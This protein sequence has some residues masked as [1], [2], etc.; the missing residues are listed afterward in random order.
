VSATNS[1]R[2][3]AAA[4]LVILP[5]CAELPFLQP[6]TGLEFQ[7]SGR[8]AVRYDG[9]G[10]SGNIAWR[11]RAAGDEMLI[12]TPLGQ[13]VARIERERDMVTVTASDRRVYRAHDAESLTEQV[14]GFR[15]PLE[16]LSD[17]VR[18]K[19]APGPARAMRDP[20]GRLSELEQ[21]GWQIY[22]LAYGEDNGLP[23][24]LRLVYPGLELR[25]AI[26]EWQV[27]P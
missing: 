20:R 27:R 13:G 12:T 21:D 2:V 8:I 14:L 26:G 19:P 6:T 4:A 9:Q 17:W 1:L 10:S 22:Y 15:V 16:G 3:L 18:G 25:L 5:A 24:R 11:H 23:S 7:L